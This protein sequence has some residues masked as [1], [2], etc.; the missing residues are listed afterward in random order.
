MLLWSVKGLLAEVGADGGEDFA[1]DVALEA[2]DDHGLGSALLGAS[3][4]V[5]AGVWVPAE[6]ADHDAVEGSVGGA[7]TAAVE[8]VAGGL[9]R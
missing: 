2:A 8:A 5:G 7:V 3:V 9:A 6:P 1:G 4:D